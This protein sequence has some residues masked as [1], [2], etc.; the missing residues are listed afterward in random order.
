MLGMSTRLARL[1]VE[2]NSLA[3]GLVLSRD[4]MRLVVAPELRL[5]HKLQRSVDLIHWED[6]ELD[7]D[8]NGTG[9]EVDASRPKE[10]FRL[11]KR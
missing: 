1:T 7:P 4:D 6:L 5:T 11:I 3:K 8:A 2:A 9:L 10:F